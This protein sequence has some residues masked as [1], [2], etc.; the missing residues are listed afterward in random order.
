MQIK[1]TMNDH[2]TPIKVANIKRIIITENNMYWRGCGETVTLVHFWC[3]YKMVH[4]QWKT[5]W[6][7]FIKLKEL[8]YDPAISLLGIYPKGLKAGSLNKSYLY[9]HIYS[10]IIHNSQEMEATQ[11][12][13]GISKIWSVHTMEYYSAL[14]RKEILT[15]ATT[16]L[17][18]RNIVLSKPV[19][20]RYGM[21]PLI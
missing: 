17:K 2:L 7:L 12:P 21:I 3:K 18:L 14:K 4:P 19:M 5:V 1:T 6:Q 8:P 15:H 16:W 11:R 9:T 10:S 13:S 20:K